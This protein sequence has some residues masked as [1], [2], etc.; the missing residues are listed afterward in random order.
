[1]MNEEINLIKKKKTKNKF[2][3]FVLCG[4]ERTILR[5]VRAQKKKI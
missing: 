2:C 5:V 4:K 3:C 1:M